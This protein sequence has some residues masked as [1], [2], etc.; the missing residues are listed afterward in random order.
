[1]EREKRMVEN[2]GLSNP[3]GAIY[4]VS[5][6]KDAEAIS[7]VHDNRGKRKAIFD[8]ISVHSLNLDVENTNVTQKL[9]NDIQAVQDKKTSN[10]SVPKNL[11]EITEAVKQRL[12]SFDIEQR[13]K[14]VDYNPTFLIALDRDDAER[15]SDVIES[16]LRT[17]GYNAYTVSLASSGEQK[18]LEESKKLNPNAFKSAIINTYLNPDNQAQQFFDWILQGY[19]P[20]LRTG[21]NKLDSILGGGINNE[22]YVLGATPGLGK[23]TLALQMATYLAQTK[24]H[25]FYYALEMSAKQMIAKT[26]NRFAFQLSG[27]GE[28]YNEVLEANPLE[29]LPNF[30]NVYKGHW[31]LTW[32]NKSGQQIMTAL[33][34]GLKMYNDLSPYLHLKD[35]MTKKPT[36]SQ[37]KEDIRNF[38]S[39]TGEKPVIFIDYLQLLQ[40]SDDLSQSTAKQRVSDAIWDLKI[41]SRDF[42]IPVFVI[43]SYNRASYTDLHA[44]MTAFKES[45][46]IDYSAE[47]IMTMSYDFDH[48]K[49]TN[50][51]SEYNSFFNKTVGEWFEA[52]LKDA[53]K[54]KDRG[55]IVQEGIN[56]TQMQ[57]SQVIRLSM[58]KNRFGGIPTPI[59]FEFRPRFDYF[60]ELNDSFTPINA[61]IPSIKDI[62]TIIKSNRLINT[63]Q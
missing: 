19:A 47:A 23:T 41:I 55:Q 6:A 57:P 33:I 5:T 46:D 32:G 58:L 52:Q 27:Y 35:N 7:D 20:S 42:Q 15:F 4:V 28:V 62:H 43:S 8:A 45:G 10:N 11:D 61:K 39:R 24:H 63:E 31:N 3:H 48:T 1:M 25:V 60:C 17:N 40:S 13:R 51:P 54:S 38:I 59:Y 22:L 26:V 21:W 18:T 14:A 50:A 16:T 37:V 9:L 44:G 49:I 29:Q 36:V 30:F 56:L 34:N 12:E 53:K 2:K